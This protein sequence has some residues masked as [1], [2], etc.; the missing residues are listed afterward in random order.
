MRRWEFDAEL[1]K[2]EGING[3]YVVFPYDLK[4]ETGRARMKVHAWF[5]GVPYDGSLVHYGSGAGGI[6]C[7]GVTKAVRAAIGKQPP[8]VVHV[9]LTEREAEQ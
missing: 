9:V 6:T 5:D 7:I 2:V 1:K 4:A 3:A 8:A